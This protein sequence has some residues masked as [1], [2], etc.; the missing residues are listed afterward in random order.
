MEVIDWSYLLAIGIV[1]IGLEAMIFS[2]F[3]VWLGV[4]FVI[5]AGLS[6]FG[7]FESG[8]AQIATA[9]SIGLVLVF[10]LRKWSMNMVNK[11]EDDSEEKIHK[12]GVGTVD[13]GMMKLDGTFWQTDDDLSGYKDGDKVEVADIINNKA[14]LA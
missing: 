13:K 6:Y 14:K 9:V 3:L 8:T 4:G 12:G 10:V 1:M 11:T 2:F 5:V 7:L